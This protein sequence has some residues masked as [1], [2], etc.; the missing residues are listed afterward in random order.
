M[1]NENNDL[2]IRVKR[3]E[4]NYKTIL[5]VQRDTERDTS[6]EVGK[7]TLA[8]LAKLE[9]T[10][11]AVHKTL[12]IEGVKR[13]KRIRTNRIAIWLAMVAA[14]VGLGI[15]FAGYQ[16]VKDANNERD[17]SRIAA[18]YQYNDQ[19]DTAINAEIAQS[20]FF[21]D[22]LT[23][24]STNPNIQAIKNEYNDE[25]DLLVREGHPH[26]DCSPKGIARYLSKKRN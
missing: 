25:F 4:D 1:T 14:L 11:E 15:G 3:L 12:K 6:I 18:C 9:G 5:D 7:A 23:R 13:D 24:S 16:N 19:Q 8:R 2:L 17:A 22:A 26:R 10:L 20:H 21:V